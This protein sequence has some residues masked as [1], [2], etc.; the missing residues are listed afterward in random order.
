MLPLCCV[1]ISA[2]QNCTHGWLWNFQP[3]LTAECCRTTYLHQTYNK[4]AQS[5]TGA[6]LIV[7]SYIGAIQLDQSYT[8]DILLAQS[9]TGAFLFVHSY[10]GAIL[11]DQSYTGAILLANLIQE[12]NC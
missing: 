1:Y 3:F 11:L 10:I 2:D 8:G 6:F 7:H 5:Y 4:I 9:Y 12:L